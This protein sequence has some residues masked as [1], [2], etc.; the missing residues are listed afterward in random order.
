MNNK[1]IRRS[2]RSKISTLLIYINVFLFL[3][4]E[5]MQ[6]SLLQSFKSVDFGNK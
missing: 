6:F 4:K 1:N 5:T 3:I 2:S